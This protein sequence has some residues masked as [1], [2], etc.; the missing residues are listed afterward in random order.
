MDGRCPFF[1][2]LAI[3]SHLVQETFIKCLPGAKLCGGLFSRS[4]YHTA[5]R[6]ARREVHLS[7]VFILFV[8][9]IN[10]FLINFFFLINT[11]CTQKHAL[12]PQWL[13]FREIKILKAKLLTNLLLSYVIAFREK[14][15]GR[16]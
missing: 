1:W 3:D 8:S 7:S 12:C 5:V 11:K 16:F 9:E 14:L 15:S 2:T 10:H 6:T 4:G 13:G